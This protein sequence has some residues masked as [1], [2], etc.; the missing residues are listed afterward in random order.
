M[1]LMRIGATVVM[2]AVLGLVPGAQAAGPAGAAQRATAGEQA[3]KSA[4]DFYQRAK[5][6]AKAGKADLAMADLDRAIALDPAMGAAYYDRALLHFKK[7]DVD[8]AIDDY[9][10]AIGVLPEFPPAYRERGSALI[11]KRAFKKAIANFDQAIKLKA[12]YADAFDER[13]YA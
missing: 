5:A 4:G 6:Y 13:G 9:S 8:K 11:A 7:G 3:L 10:K 1:T 12:D 2:L